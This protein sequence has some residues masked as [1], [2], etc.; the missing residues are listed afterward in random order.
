MKHLLVIFFMALLPGFAFATSIKTDLSDAI[1]DKTIKLDAVNVAGRYIGKTTKLVLTNTTKS[2]LQVK[3][4]LG[5]ILSPDDSDYQPMVLAG[6][7]LLVVM[8]GKTGEVEVETFCGN[9]PRNC[10][11]KDLHYTFSRVASDTLIKIL[12]FVKTYSLYDFLGQH[13]V[14]AFTN[15]RN[16]S[17][18]Y[19]SDRDEL[20]KKFIDAIC[21]ATGWPKPGYYNLWRENETPG[22]PAFVPKTLKIYAEFEV[23]LDAPKTMTLGVFDGDGKMIQKVFENKEFPAMGHR[24]GV[25]FEAENVTAGK[26]YIRLKEGEAVLQEKMVKVD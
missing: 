7:E 25:E 10:P 3:I 2:V 22:Q 4:N 18:V 19:E 11:K 9:S 14:W 20:S 1:K 17:G 12:R 13:G 16:L 26:Y 6:E 21:K 5:V 24:F 23:R 8:P 15:D